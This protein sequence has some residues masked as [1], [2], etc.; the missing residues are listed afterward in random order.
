MNLYFF[1]EGEQTEMA[2]YPAWIERA[3]PQLE[4]VGRLEDVASNHYLLFSG[5][6]YPSYLR[7]IKNSLDEIEQ[8]GA[9]D[10][11]FVCVD[12][13]EIPVE[14]KLAEIEELITGRSLNTACHT[15]VQNCC[16]ETWFLGNSAMMSRQPNNEPL[17]SWREFYDVRVNC[18]ESM[19]YPPGG[20]YRLRAHFHEDYLRAMLREKRVIYKKA[21]PV[22]ITDPNNHY[23]EN[24]V[25]RHEQ[26]KHIQTFGR[27]LEVWRSLGAKI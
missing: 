18:P 22:A 27:L 9:I 16:I 20:R 13:E 6:G 12:A 15:I 1:V 25:K 5:Q 8:H 24:L 7:H 26:T 11:F 14:E 19:N 3:F 10:H 2:V 4:R 23:L 21:N 17:R